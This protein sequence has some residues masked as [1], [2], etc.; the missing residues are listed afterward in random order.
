MAK[1]ARWWWRSTLGAEPVSVAAGVGGEILL[2]TFMDRHGE[3]IGEALNLRG[4]E[5]VIVGSPADQAG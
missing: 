2:S 4:N 5:G 3:K 1:Q